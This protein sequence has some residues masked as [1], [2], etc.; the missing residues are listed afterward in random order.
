[1]S[2]LVPSSAGSRPMGSRRVPSKR[3][4]VDRLENA[5]QKGFAQPAGAFN[6]HHVLE[7]KNHREARGESSMPFVGLLRPNL[8]K[9]IESL[10]VS[11]TPASIRT[12]DLLVPNQEPTNFQ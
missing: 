7:D 5:I 2:E 4:R 12:A 1:M 11:A 6:N 8:P 10:T 3:F 9:S